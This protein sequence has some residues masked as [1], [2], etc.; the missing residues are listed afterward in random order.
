MKACVHDCQIEFICNSSVTTSPAP[1]LFQHQD[2]KFSSSLPPL[3]F[4][5]SKDRAATAAAAAGL[6]GGH[7]R[8]TW[9]TKGPSYEDLYTQNVVINMDDQEDLHRASLEGKS[10]KERPIW[11]RESTVQGAYSSEE[12]KEGKSRRSKMN[13]SWVW[14]KMNLPQEITWASL[15]FIGN[16][17]CLFY[18]T[19]ALQQEVN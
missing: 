15:S 19:I 12:M 8:E 4:L 3:I 6:A 7:H 18:K 2:F 1:L 17:L 5:F 10:A 11:L 14:Q 13:M 9:A 16:P